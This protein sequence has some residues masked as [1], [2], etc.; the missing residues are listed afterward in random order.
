M[1]GWRTLQGSFEFDAAFEVLTLTA[2][3]RSFAFFERP[4]R[5]KLSARVF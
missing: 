5:N 4:I 2:F 3:S 1:V